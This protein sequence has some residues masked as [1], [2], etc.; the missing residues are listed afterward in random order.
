VAEF[1]RAGGPGPDQVAGLEQMPLDELR[2]KR[3]DCARAETELSYLRR[4][5]QAR[6]DLVMAEGQSRRGGRRPSGDL[7]ERLAHILGDHQRGQGSGGRLPAFFAPDEGVQA[8]LAARVEA[9]LPSD[10]L[11]SLA[12]LDQEVLDAVLGELTALEREVSR[13]RRELHDVMDR[14]QE[15]VVRRYRTGEATVD[16]LL[17]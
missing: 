6:I 5:A 13:Q 9:V 14:L 17:G 11:G 3:D 2:A 4:L 1:E 7:V 15:E 12:E 16:A 8:D 10:R